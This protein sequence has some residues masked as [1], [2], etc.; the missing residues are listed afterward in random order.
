MLPVLFPVINVEEVVAVGSGNCIALMQTCVHV[1]EMLGN[2]HFR[3]RLGDFPANQIR[4]KQKKSLRNLIK[5]KELLAVT[6][7]N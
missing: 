1:Y 6:M 3:R 4:K 5:V 2:V 7:P